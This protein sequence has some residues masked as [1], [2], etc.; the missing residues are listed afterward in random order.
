MYLEVTV[1]L[2]EIEKPYRRG[3]LDKL[4]ETIAILSDTVDLEHPIIDKQGRWRYTFKIEVESI[5][6]LR[7]TLHK[8]GRFKILL[9]RD[10]GSHSILYQRKDY[11]I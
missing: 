5:A 4:L 9:I 2:G 1:A 6:V 8:N 7:E 3:R 11:I 10:V